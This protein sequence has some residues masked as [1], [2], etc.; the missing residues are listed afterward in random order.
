[1]VRRP[2]PTSAPIF[3]DTSRWTHS[4]LTHFLSL[5]AAIAISLA[6]LYGLCRFGHDAGVP[7]DWR[8]HAF[9]VKLREI[10]IQHREL[11]QCGITPT[12]TVGD[13]YP[14]IIEDADPEEARRAERLHLPEWARDQLRAWRAERGEVTK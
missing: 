4:P 3:A 5:V 9:D 7:V 13:V 10:N 6:L 8:D 14:Q 1:M 2:R 12:L 11:E